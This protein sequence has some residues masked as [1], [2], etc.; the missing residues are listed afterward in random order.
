[1]L[2]LVVIETCPPTPPPPTALKTKSWTMYPRH[3]FHSAETENHRVMFRVS[4]GSHVM[5]LYATVCQQTINLCLDRNPK[6]FKPSAHNPTHF[7]CSR[8][9]GLYWNLIFSSL[10]CWNNCIVRRLA[11]QVYG[12]G[13]CCPNEVVA[14]SLGFSRPFSYYF[15][16]FIS[17]FLPCSIDPSFKWNRNDSLY[18]TWHCTRLS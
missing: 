18:S 10:Y 9:I 17:T 4:K 13:S 6:C 2:R 11:S 7:D 16:T 1:M 8:T 3:L 14:T 5:L 15:T 12:G